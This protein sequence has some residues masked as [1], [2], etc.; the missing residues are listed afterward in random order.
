MSGGRRFHGSRERRCGRPRFSVEQSPLPL[1]I[2]KRRFTDPPLA[3][4]ALERISF[5][6]VPPDPV[7]AV[8]TR[9]ARIK[10]WRVRDLAGSS[11]PRSP[12]SGT[13][14]A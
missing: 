2:C 9:R 4:A 1:V 6:S 10:L 5:L 13:S 7:N 12:A 14:P 11:P 8:P 3:R